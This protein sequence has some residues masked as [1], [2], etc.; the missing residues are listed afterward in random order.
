[1]GSFGS[2]NFTLPFGLDGSHATGLDYVPFNGYLAELH[3]GEGIL[4]AEENRIWQRFKNG[5]A[6]SQNVDYD[7]LGSAMRDN[8][9]PGGNVYLDSRVVGHVIS[10]QQANSYR[11][12]QR[13]GWQQ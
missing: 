10:K 3:E 8:V 13:S 9:K 12:L 7:M 11:S 1:M 5:G 2:I 4:T 6:A